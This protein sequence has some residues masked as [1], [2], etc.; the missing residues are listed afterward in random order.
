MKP[1]SLSRVH[2]PRV[3]PKWL[4]TLMLWACLGWAHAQ[5]GVRHAD[6]ERELKQTRF[7]QVLDLT[8]KA[9]TERP[10]DPQMRFW[11]AVA[12]DKLGRNNEALEAYRSLCQDHPELPEPHN[13]L[14]VMLLRAGQID[15]AQAAFEWALRMDASYAAAMENLGDVLVLQARRWYEKS[16]ETDARRPTLRQK[17]NALPE[18]PPRTTP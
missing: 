16:L 13:N 5:S 1:L 7:E 9:L 8:Q 15:E 3:D 10:R 11:R 4:L 17:I 12:L 2:A 18:P 14:G 6:V